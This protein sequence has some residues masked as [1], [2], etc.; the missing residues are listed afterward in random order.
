MHAACTYVCSM[1]REPLTLDEESKEFIKLLLGGLHPDRWRGEERRGEERRGEERRGEERRGEERRGEERRGG[2]YLNE[3]ICK[4]DNVTK[5]CRHYFT[6]KHRELVEEVNTCSN[7][8]TYFTPLPL[9]PRNSHTLT[10]SPLPL[11]SPFPLSPL[12]PDVLTQLQDILV[13]GD[14]LFEHGGVLNVVLD[15]KDQAPHTIVI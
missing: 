12:V 11:H 15:T 9:Q 1:S 7:I 8:R 10:L 13:A 14:V 3:I 6:H 5:T 4:K 2:V